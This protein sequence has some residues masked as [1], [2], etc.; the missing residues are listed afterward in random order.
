MLS[1]RLTMVL[2][3]LHAVVFM[4]NS[5]SQCHHV[6]IMELVTAALYLSLVSRVFVQEQL[7]KQ[8]SLGQEIF[9]I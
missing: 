6:N 3:K 8:C 5:Q 9:P 1:I 7:K 4:Y 2:N